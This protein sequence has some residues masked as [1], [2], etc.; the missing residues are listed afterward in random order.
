MS[1]FSISNHIVSE[2][3][4]LLFPD[5]K[6]KEIPVIFSPH[7]DDAILGCG[8]LIQYFTSHQIPLHLIIF[9]KGDAGY[10]TVAEK[11][12]VVERRKRETIEC[13]GKLGI[14]KENI[15]YFDVPDFSM[16]V[17][18]PR[19][20]SEDEKG[21]FENLVAYLREIRA[22]R[23]IIPNSYM[24][25]SDHEAVYRCGIYDAV[26]AS[27]PILAELGTPIDLKS[28]LIYAVWTDFSPVNALLHGR[29][30]K[31][32]ADAGVCMPASVEDTVID[33]IRCYQSQAAIIDQLIQ[34]R[35]ARKTRFGW[36]EL[37]QNIQ[38]RPSLRYENYR[39]CIESLYEE[40]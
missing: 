23:I 35:Q 11:A 8:Y 33:A 38:F 25:H 3:I 2:D 13:Y 4:S 10:S 16:Q 19:Y 30:E 27:D 12:S 14:K 40:G 29:N 15:L 22:T 18:S 28:M 31:I 9:C 37:Y 7:D 26:Q 36:A 17:F 34:Q 21:T 1:F 20:R 32:R 24:E 6:E 5:W 39:G